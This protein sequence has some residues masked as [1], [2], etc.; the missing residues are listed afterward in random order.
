MRER[1][2]T[3]S[4]KCNSRTHSEAVEKG[5]VVEEASFERGHLQTDAVLS[6]SAVE[7][8]AVDQIGVLRRREV[9]AIV[10]LVTIWMR[11]NKPDRR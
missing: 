3:E 4:N 2:S 11:S 1:C 9:I 7:D 8:F 5:V 10:W 6:D